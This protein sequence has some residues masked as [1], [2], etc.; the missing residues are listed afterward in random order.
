[1]YGSWL[2]S[3]YC[4]ARKCCLIVGRNLPD[5]VA[6]RVHYSVFDGARVGL[7]NPVG[8]LVIARKVGAGKEVERVEG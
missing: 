7:I 2:A 1:M 5:I 3:Q 8:S 6:Y 4:N